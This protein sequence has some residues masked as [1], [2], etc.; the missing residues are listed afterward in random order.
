MAS[1]RLQ[2]EVGHASTE[3]TKT[4]GHFDKQMRTSSEREAPVRFQDVPLALQAAMGEFLRARGLTGP[5]TNG[6]KWVPTMVVLAREGEE[7]K[8]TEATRKLQEGYNAMQAVARMED[9]YAKTHQE[10]AA[11]RE[12]LREA[13][14]ANERLEQMQ[15]EKLFAFTEKI[16]AKSFHILCAVLAQGDVA[17]ASR[18]LNVSDATLR[19]RIR[20]W[21][22][23]GQAYRLAAELVRWRK[24]MGR[25]GTVLLN[26]AITKESAAA[27][28][29]AGLLADVLDEVLTMD[30]GN[31]REKAEALAAL[32][33]PQV[34]G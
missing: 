10:I 16:D 25:K 11:V 29:F 8:A 2:F 23:G 31:W 9:L 3:R 24:A 21:E 7:A 22:T 30:E 20:Q 27:V 18:A 1:V 34:G 14:T 6:E 32:L 13:K 15:A 5:G 26:E 19:S 33:R 17:K 28:D 4:I 12:D